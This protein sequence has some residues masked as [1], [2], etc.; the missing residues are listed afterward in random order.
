MSVKSAD[1][2]LSEAKP[3]RTIQCTPNVLRGSGRLR[4]ELRSL[5][6]DD[7]TLFRSEATPTLPLRHGRGLSRP[8]TRQ[9]ANHDPDLRRRGGWPGQAAAMTG[10]EAMGWNVP[11]RS[12]RQPLSP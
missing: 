7:T 3:R 5:D 10:K 2:I 12:A 9:D 11:W 1:L 4:V 6:R 8:P